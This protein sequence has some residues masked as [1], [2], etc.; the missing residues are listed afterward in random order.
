ML[1]CCT[2]NCLKYRLNSFKNI[3]SSNE[4]K[5]ITSCRAVTNNIN[6]KKIEKNV[7]VKKVE[8]NDVYK[9]IRTLSIHVWPKN[10]PKLKA[11]VVAAV[12]FLFG[13]KLLN[14]QVP[15]L[16][17]YAIDSLNDS[18]L[19]INDVETAVVSTVTAMILGYGAA[20][21]GSCLFNELRNAVFAQVTQNAIRKVSRET[22][23]H[24]HKLDMSYHLSRQ[25]GMLSKAIDRGTSGIAY[26]LHA[27]VFNIF[28]TIFEVSLVSCI[29]TYSCGLPFTF[30]AL[31]C[32][33]IYAAFTFS[34][35]EWRTKFRIQMNNADNE[36]GIRA[37][38]S[39]INYETVKYFNNESFE[40]EQYDKLLQKYE[41]ASIKTATS[42]AFLNFG[43]NLIFST[44]LTAVMLMASQSIIQ[45]TM[46][47]GDLVMINGLLYQLTIPLNFLGTVYR[48]LRQSIIDMQS[49]FTLLDIKSKVIESPKAVPL[50]FLKGDQKDITFENICFQYPNGPVIF[51]DLSFTIK[52]GKK[53][54]IVGGSGSG[55]STVV[56]LLYRFFDPNDGKILIGH[57]DIKDYTIESLR[58]SI[59][60]V[61]Q[62]QVLFNDTILYNVQYGRVSATAEEVFEA[63]KMAD[64]HDSV[65]R[66]PKGYQ[67]PVGERGL[68]LSGGEKQRVAI[69]RAVLKTSPILIYDEATSS[70]DS[71]TEKNI[72]E[73]IKLITKD[74]TSL[75]IAHRLSTITDA[76]EILVIGDKKIAESGTHRELLADSS[77]FYSYLWHKQNDFSS[78]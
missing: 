78:F 23:M 22:F 25:T 19:V 46:T 56:R 17:K 36:C 44:T 70:L 67:T 65:M 53:T 32:I 76:D 8:K 24:L 55:K 34:V 26:F 11:R 39:L 51:K 30:T 13:A 71:I 2:R 37:M 47:I 38:D 16:F 62:D 40:T 68:M 45:G 1:S 60:V 61:P 59:G 75:F 49:I 64:I 57:R 73:S 27:L 58:K 3:L 54:A 18:P 9:V 72:L 35:T 28:P 7:D 12:G 31:S 29:L 66:M 74:R 41:E 5:L 21:T 48:D 43:Q 42:L 69:A 10:E 20:R 4:L 63:A 50:L 77:S 6:D 52:Y 15:F 33:G 14:V